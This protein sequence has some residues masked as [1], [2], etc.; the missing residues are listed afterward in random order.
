MVQSPSWE[1]NWFAASQILLV[2][3]IVYVTVT[4]FKSLLRCYLRIDVVILTVCHS[5]QWQKT[6]LIL[7]KSR[8]WAGPPSTV[9]TRSVRGRVRRTAERGSFLHV[10]VWLSSDV[11]YKTGL[12]YE[13]HVV[14]GVSE[15]TS[16][17]FVAVI[18]GFSRDGGSRPWNMWPLCP[19][20]TLR[21]N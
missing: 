9:G 19:V 18:T 21:I 8:L 2:R 3:K 6:F 14:C 13:I 12:P 16:P 10:L 7:N 5:G 20:E 11:K 1:A 17:F 4:E 15:V